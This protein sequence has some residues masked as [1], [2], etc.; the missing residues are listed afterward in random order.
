MRTIT[1]QEHFATPGF[2][3]GLG[4][5]LKQQARQVGS[6]AERLMRDLCDIDQGRIAQMDAAGID[7][8][9]ISLTAP[10]VEQLEAAEAVALARD[11]NDALAEAIARRPTRLS[12]FAA[13]PV[14]APDQAAKE[15]EHRFRKQAFAGAVINGH[16]RGR[17]LDDKF[18]WPCWRPPKRSAR[19]SICIRPS[20]P[21]R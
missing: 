6:R 11:T 14:A 16:Q 5:D 1:L 7:M 2:L 13:L 20:R 9:V 8:Q 3:D 21:G 15:L 17:Y 10:G 12:G 19:R 4:R 18:F